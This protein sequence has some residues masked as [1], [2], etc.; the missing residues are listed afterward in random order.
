[1]PDEEPGKESE[2]SA[3]GAPDDI[4]KPED[5]DDSLLPAAQLRRLPRTTPVTVTLIVLFIISAVALLGVLSLPVLREYFEGETAFWVLR[6]GLL[7]MIASIVIYFALRE[8]ASLRFAE[9]LLEQTTEG[10]QRLR[11]LLHAERDIGSALELEATLDQTL[12]YAFAVT[13]CE[14]GAIYLWDKVEGALNLA[15]VR[16][17]DEG[18]MAGA[19][20][21]RGEGLLGRAVDSQ[22]LLAIDDASALEEVDNAFSGA[23]APASQVV[24]P[25]L[26]GGKFVGVLAAGTRDPHVYTPAEKRMLEGLAELASLSVTNAELYRIARR[27]LKAAARQ[28]EFTGLV[29]DEMVAGVMTSDSRG[30]ITVFNREAQRLTG[31]A[32]DDISRVDPRPGLTLEQSPLGPLEQGMAE[33]LKDPSSVRQGVASILKKDGTLLP[34]SYRVNPLVEG[35]VVLGATAVFLEDEEPSRAPARKEG[36]DYQLLLRSMGSRIEMLHIHPLE[37]VVEKVRGMDSED[38][39]RG[40]DETLRALEDGSAALAGLLE[41][42]EQYLNCVATREWDTP[43]ECDMGDMVARVVEKVLRSRETEGVVVSVRLADIPP[44]FGYERMINM[45][46]EQVIENA[47]LAAVDGGKK[48]EVSGGWGDVYVRVEVADTGGGVP[49]DARESIYQPFFTLREGRSGLG[50]SI[51][52][53]VMERLGGRVGLASCEPGAVFFLELPASPEAAGGEGG[54]GPAAEGM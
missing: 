11:L 37:R 41:D 23:A 47:C 36:V 7:V 13:G 19:R 46:L 40:R 50:L 52:Q 42:V 33:V 39:A 4:V 27:S 54:T 15:L 22:E 3:S 43:T 51:V 53:R 18:D 20:V 8:R 2:E 5:A 38:W 24:V 29:L 49:A 44:V 48:V 28:R 6:I 1:M 26:A 25:L 14:M 30:C 35:S 21:R 17:V 12:K 34:I 32:P 10:N 45:A 9:K 31:Y 16:G